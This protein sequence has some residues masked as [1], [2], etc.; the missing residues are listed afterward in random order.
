MG[1][2]L[3]HSF[4]ITFNTEGFLSQSALYGKLT[5]KMRLSTDMQ[6]KVLL[7]TIKKL[8]LGFASFQN[9]HRTVV[10]FQNL[11]FSVS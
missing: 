7:Q 6:A 3:R 2:L 5:L 4:F 1:E 11:P 10:F 8:I 9:H